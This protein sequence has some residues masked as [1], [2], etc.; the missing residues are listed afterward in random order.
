MIF[1]TLRILPANGCSASW[2]LLLDVAR[3]E[4]GEMLLNLSSR[5]LKPLLVDAA[6]RER[7]ASKTRNINIRLDVQ[8]NLPPVPVDAEQI[9]RL[10]ANLLDNAIKYT[11]DNAEV[12][13]AA[14]ELDN[15]IVVSVVDAGSGI[16]VEERERIF[17][18]FAQ[19]PGG[20]PPGAGLGW[21][22]HSA[23]LRLKRTVVK[24]G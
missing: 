20:N 23:G 17:E 1:L 18:R 7:L 11:P 12:V 15:A 16:A 2:I 3:L 19:A 4:T 13:L 5:Y 6:Y 9:D 22:S 10:L 8:D 24:S 14:E 21:A